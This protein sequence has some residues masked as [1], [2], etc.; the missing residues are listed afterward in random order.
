M[1]SA[2]HHC[3]NFLYNGDY[4][5]DIRIIL[6]DGPEISKTFQEVATTALFDSPSLPY[7]QAAREFVAFAAVNEAISRLEQMGVEEILANPWLKTILDEM[8]TN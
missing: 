7:T 1:H 3:H 6:D 8:T 5:G 4:S 2:T